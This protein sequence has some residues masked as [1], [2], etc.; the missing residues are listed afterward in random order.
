MNSSYVV[1]VLA[2]DLQMS[3]FFLNLMKV[4]GFFSTKLHIIPYYFTE[5][6]EQGIYK[7]LCFP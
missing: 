5:I 4:T 3:D 6:H 7:H 1:L 2:L